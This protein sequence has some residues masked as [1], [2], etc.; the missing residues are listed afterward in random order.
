MDNNHAPL[1]QSTNSSPDLFSPLS[2]SLISSSSRVASQ[3]SPHRFATLCATVDDPDQNH[4]DRFGSSSVPIYQ[5]STFKGLDGQYDYTRSGNPSRT[6]L[7][8]HVAKISAAKHAFAVSSG[9]AALDVILRTLQPGDEIIAGNDLYGGSNRLLAYINQHNGILT[10]HIDTTNLEIIKPFLVKDSRVR[11]VL[12]ESPTNP[13]L[14]IVDIQAIINLVKPIIPEA[15]IVVDNTMMS[16]YLMKPLEFGADVVYDSGTKFLSGHHDLMAGLITCNS[17]KIASQ[18]AFVINSIGNGLAPFECFLLTRGI[19]TLSLRFDRQQASANRIAKYLDHLG[20]KVNYPGLPHH[21]GKEIHDRLAKGPGA[22]LSFETGDKH[23]SE[24]IVSS[25]RLW[26]ISVSFG[27][28]NSLISMPCLMSHASIDPAVRAARN[29][30]ED[31]IRLCVGIE[32]PDDLLE[33]LQAALVEAGAI[34]ILDETRVD[35][36]YERVGMASLPVSP[37][38]GMVAHEDQLGSPGNPTTLLV[39][40]PGKIILFGEHAVVYGKKAI[41]AAV[42]RR[43]YCYIEPGRHQVN[44]TVTLSLPDSGWTGS[45][46]LNQLPWDSVKPSSDGELQVDAQLSQALL[47]KISGQAESNSL[48]QAAHAF[49]Y[50]FMQLATK[51]NRRSQVFTVRS[52]LPIGA[53]LGSSASYSV[54][55]ASALLYSHQHIAIPTRKEIGRAEVESINRW[56]FLGEKILHGSPSG[57]DN[58]VSSFGGAICFQKQLGDDKKQKQLI[59]HIQG[60]GA[61]RILI[62]DTQVPRDTKSLVAGVA[63]R[64]GNDPQ[65]IQR[66]LDDI[67]DLTIS[68]QE[69][70]QDLATTQESRENGAQTPSQDLP[71]VKRDSIIVKLGD[72]MA[73]NHALLASLGVSHSQLELVKSITASSDLKTKLTGAGGGGCAI[74]LIPDKFEP[75]KLSTIMKEIEEKQMKTY[76]TEIGVSGVGV[77]NNLHHHHELQ[78]SIKKIYLTSSLGTLSHALSSSPSHQPL[79]LGDHQPQT[80]GAGPSSSSAAAA[81]AAAGGGGPSHLKI[82]WSF[83]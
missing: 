11:M 19:K 48:V 36:G 61:I 51:E 79:H 49:L 39:S 68:A 55:L 24:K 25:A 62:S 71:A 67:E 45:W 72:L 80:N 65:G 14:Q 50:L 73:R 43:C 74:T 66:I 15:I 31:L 81:A 52:T 6:F 47:A 54:C 30:P 69:S 4:K 9:M 12:L 2:A 53:G 17:D 33:D 13:L 18:L 42:N 38:R 20:F 82:F 77:L 32:D 23:L 28:V 16:P 27:C 10:H 35:S 22:V 46:P 41:A 76:E 26:G 59:E 3:P 75:E 44:E 58:T 7:Q 29:L 57:V 40:A 64:K 8:H 63:L 70:I 78:E 60:F 21:K 1:N 34:R 83:A 37:A 56:A 5:C